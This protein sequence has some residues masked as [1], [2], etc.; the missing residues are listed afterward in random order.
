MC[1][2]AD[3]ELT[4]F[5]EQ[6]KAHKNEFKL[7][8]EEED[9]YRARTDQFMRESTEDSKR[10]TEAINELLK[11]TRG[12]IE[13]HQNY[14]AGKKITAGIGKIAMWIA[15][16]GAAATAIHFIREQFFN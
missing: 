16:I 12:V 1:R 4:K 15:S 5:Y 3:S 13:I 14:V 9:S 2:F 7:H 11:E 6:F 10:H 8:M